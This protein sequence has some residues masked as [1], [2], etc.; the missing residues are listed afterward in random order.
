MST[1]ERPFRFGLQVARAE[2]RQAWQD[3]ARRAEDLGFDTIVVPDHI[4]DDLFSPMVALATMAEATTRLRVGTFVLNNDFRHP[5]LLAREAA[6]VDLL[7][8]GRLELG[9]GAG[10]SAPEYSEIGLPFDPAGVRVARLEE[11]A[12]L[13]RKLFDGEAVTFA[14]THYQ[15]V[16]HR[17]APTRRPTLLVGG[18]GDRVLALG[19]RYADIVGLTG[20][21]RTLP[22]GQKHEI[23]WRP[24]Q[25]DAKVAV[26]RAA[27]GDRGSDLGQLELNALVQY[28]EITP[29][30]RASAE[31]ISAHLEVDP[32]VLMDA[33][34][35]LIGTIEEIVE[36][37]H[38]DRDRW[39]FSYYVTRDPAQTAPIIAAL[40]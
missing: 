32:D 34:Y 10:H 18:N 14:G 12:Q 5:A 6:T 16:T 11:S 21:G 3:E 9:L 40:R 1:P 31:Q 25:I 19:A 26:V 23:E 30:R 33:P 37:L 2:S 17:L 20:T 15:V 7:T 8:D 38:R 28:V 36:Q 4:A 13:L 22:D 39:G 27:A 35:L 24:D 29:D